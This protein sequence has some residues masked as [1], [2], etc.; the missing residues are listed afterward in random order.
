MRVASSDVLTLSINLGFTLYLVASSF[1]HTFNLSRSV[2]FLIELFED[3]LRS[4]SGQGWLK[5]LFRNISHRGIEC[6]KEFFGC[7][8]FR[9]F[10]V[11]GSIAQEERLEM[12]LIY[13]CAVGYYGRLTVGDDVRIDVSN[14][15]GGEDMALAVGVPL[16]IEDL[17]FIEPRLDRYS[18]DLEVSRGVE[19]ISY[20]LMKLSELTLSLKAL[21]RGDVKILL[22]DG[23]I[24]G[25]YGPLLR[26][27]RVLTSTSRCILEGLDTVYGKVSKADLVLAGNIGSGIFHIPRRGIYAK[28][29]LI[30]Y[31]IDN[32]VGEWV[33]VDDVI[34]KVG[35]GRRVFK[36]ALKLNSR[37]NGEVFE[38]KNGSLRINDSL[39]NY[40]VRV[41]HACMEVVN[42]ILSGVKHPLML[43]GRWITSLDIN[44]LNLILLYKILDVA[45]RSNILA[46]G[47]A[48]DTNATDL[49][50]NVKLIAK[51]GS[52][53]SRV[54]NLRSDRALLTILSALNYEYVKT[55][56]RTLEYDYCLS[57]VLTEDDGVKAVRKIIT[58]ECFLIKSYFQLRSSEL[59]P[60]V[61]SPVFCYDRPYYP[62]FDSL[63]VTR[64]EAVEEGRGTVINPFIEGRTNSSIG[65]IVLHVLSLSDNPNVIEEMGHNHLLFLSDKLAKTYSRQA[66]TMIKGVADMELGSVARRYKAYFASRRFRDIRL[67]AE[68][69]REAK[70]Y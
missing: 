27:F 31:L 29:A 40:W 53:T 30:K 20:A 55:P 69:L 7:G 70:G 34:S 28:Y 48:K 21:G 23:L 15:E 10:G 43:G 41:E 24:S 3:R 61:R 12:L 64:I 65:D 33:D 2:R 1:I 59:D 45:L 36:E 57:T 22:F 18:S 67:E 54:F 49:I 56:W 60:S 58:R 5:S 68:R 19:S 52:L 42:H 66:Q 38:F 51:S 6:F 14:P 39:R 37:L 50:R 26:D 46:V 32:H 35:V 4:V 9:I 47:I 63:N 13:S 11:D 16:W 17:P 44:T 25:S 8:D 62:S